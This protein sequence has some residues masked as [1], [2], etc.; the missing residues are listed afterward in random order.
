MLKDNF[1]LNKRRTSLYKDAIPYVNFHHVNND[2]TKYQNSNIPK[3][4]RNKQFY[5]CLRNSLDD[6][7]SNLLY[8]NYL[9][10]S[11]DYYDNNTLNQRF[12]FSQS[13]IENIYNPKVIN[14]PK[15]NNPNTKKF[16]KTFIDIKDIM[17]A[18]IKKLEQIENN[19]EK[20]N[21]IRNNLS[22]NIMKTEFSKPKNGEN[23]K[24]K[25]YQ[26]R[27]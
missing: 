4:N 6:K 24:Q 19:N 20:E 14:I 5:I 11:N 8:D 23:S 17:D 1:I 22:S 18:K 21:K 9:N 10:N 12:R 2:L 26:K 7:D 27:Y 15:L 13:I 16:S 25:S 3:D